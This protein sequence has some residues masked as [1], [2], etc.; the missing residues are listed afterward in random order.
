MRAGRRRGAAEAGA[1][2]SGGPPPPVRAQPATLA[3]LQRLGQRDASRSRD[4]TDA[5]A[6]GAA[7]RG[8]RAVLADQDARSH[9][10]VRVGEPVRRVRP[11]LPAEARGRG[12]RRGP[13]HRYRLYPAR[14]PHLPVP[15]LSPPAEARARLRAPDPR[16]GPDDRLAAADLRLPPRAGRRAALSVASPDLGPGVER[17]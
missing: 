11:V 10:P 4:L 9:D 15:R 2:V 12:Y 13:P 5:Q 3:P 1:S 8:S 7:P 6:R 14:R 16:G 17:A